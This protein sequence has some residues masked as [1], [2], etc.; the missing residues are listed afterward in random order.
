MFPVFEFVALLNGMTK[1]TCGLLLDRLL[2]KRMIS[3]R[4][5]VGVGGDVT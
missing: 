4:R 5:G 2:I 1:G 3:D